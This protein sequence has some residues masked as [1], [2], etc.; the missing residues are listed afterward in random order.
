MGLDVAGVRRWPPARRTLTVRVAAI[1]TSWPA[2][3]GMLDAPIATRAGGTDTRGAQRLS[4]RPW[5]AAEWQRFGAGGIY[6]DAAAMASTARR[7]SRMLR[8]V[9]SRMS[10]TAASLR[11][12]ARRATASW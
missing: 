8:F 12:R 11:P 5:T 10:F 4:R 6:R 3:Q 1:Q 2:I 9:R 7:A